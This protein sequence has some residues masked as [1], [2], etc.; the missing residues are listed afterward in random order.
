MCSSTFTGRHLLEDGLEVHLLKEAL[1]A[2]VN[3]LVETLGAPVH[4][5]TEGLGAP[6]V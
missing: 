5:L 2:S 4:I 3:L 1:G 6:N